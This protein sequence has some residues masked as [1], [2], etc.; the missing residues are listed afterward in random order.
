M[1]TAGIRSCCDCATLADFL[2]DDGP[3]KSSARL[4][5]DLADRGEPI[6]PADCLLGGCELELKRILA[7]R[8]RL[9]EKNRLGMVWFESDD[10][11][12]ETDLARAFDDERIDLLDEV[13]FW[14][15][16]IAS[17]GIEPRVVSNESPPMLC[18]CGSEVIEDL[19]FN[20]FIDFDLTISMN[21][22]CV[23]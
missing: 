10:G 8:R 6:C 13:V 17:G 4:V 11:S 23:L 15:P 16:L 3:V 2:S 21:F 9:R 18:W 5:A 12:F 19:R 22:L 14:P 1:E 20:A 7:P